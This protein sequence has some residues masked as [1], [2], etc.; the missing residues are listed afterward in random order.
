MVFLFSA[1]IPSVLVP[2]IG[3]CL[4]N[5][6][7]FRRTIHSDFMIF[8]W[9]TTS[10][11][12]ALSSVCIVSCSF[13]ST[14]FLCFWAFVLHLWFYTQTQYHEILLQYFKVSLKFDLDF[15]PSLP[16]LLSKPFLQ[17]FEN[18][19]VCWQWPP[20]YLGIVCDFSFFATRQVPTACWAIL[21]LETFTVF[22]S[23][24]EE[25]LNIDTVRDTQGQCHFLSHRGSGV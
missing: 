16:L 8:R 20:N 17:G 23:Q 5:H 13:P 10:S 6:C 9:S 24:L 3:F 19:S 22:L 15:L 12:R 11:S 2:E 7:V 21:C 14:L 18:C 4:D 1:F 25:V